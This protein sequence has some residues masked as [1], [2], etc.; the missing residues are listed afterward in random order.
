[1]SR[2]ARDSQQTQSQQSQRARFGCRSQVSL[3]GRDVHNPL[4]ELGARGSKQLRRGA[5]RHVSVAE[6]ARECAT[7][8]KDQGRAALAE[9]RPS[10]WSDENAAKN[11]PLGLS[12]SNHFEK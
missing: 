5:G 10:D 4:S 6:L 8:L 2:L 7:K 1:M 12:G 9:Q 3:T 11:R